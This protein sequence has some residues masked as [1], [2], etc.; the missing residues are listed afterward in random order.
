MNFF[1]TEYHEAREKF[2]VAAE[3]YGLRQVRF[4]VAHEATSELFLD[5]AFVKRDPKKLVL[6]LS[7]THGIEGY[8]GSAIQAAV[9]AEPVPSGD[10]SLL[11]VH[12]VN[13]Y[14]MQFFRRANGQNVDLNRNYAKT[15]VPNPDYALF[16]S[17]LNPKTRLEFLTGK[18][19]AF[20]QL[21]RLGKARTAQAVASGQY[22]FPHGLFFMGESIQREIQL[23]QEILRS[24]F[25]EVEEAIAID[26]H[27][28]LGDRGGE[29]LFADEDLDPSAP[30]FF[31]RIFGRAVTKPDP[32]QGSYINQGRL[33][34]A[35]RDALPRAQVHAVLQEL[36]TYSFGRVLDV[37][38]RENFEWHAN[39]P[40]QGASPA[41][42]KKML[43]IFCPVDPVW[44]ENALRLGKDRWRQAVAYFARA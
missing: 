19:R 2:L 30:E 8:L 4:R 36:G 39:G 18:L 37:L 41:T 5:F 34:V 44:R 31:R 33:S 38:R 28:G 23:L 43:E 9:L 3:E 20:Y 35:I 13:P 26:V 6:H 40:V 42:Q 24:H 1:S 25:P 10:A 11:F 22:T 32:A 16:N 7:G 29:W 17:F 27:S 12:A 14:G 21:K 15:K